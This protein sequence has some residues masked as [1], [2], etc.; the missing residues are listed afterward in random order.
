MPELHP[1]TDA[2]LY[3]WEF[4]EK[5]RHFTVAVPARVLSTASAINR[6]LAAAG[7]G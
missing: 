3:R 7:P 2:P 1:A 5:G 4:T 6:R